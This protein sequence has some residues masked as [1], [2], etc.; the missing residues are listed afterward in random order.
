[1][2]SVM[3]DI[4]ESTILRKVN[5]RLLPI[6]MLLFFLSLLDRT[7]VSFAAWR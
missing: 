1:M 5:L 3:P 2:D 6:S 7:N 4:S